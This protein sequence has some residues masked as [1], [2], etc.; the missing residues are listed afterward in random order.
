MQLPGALRA[1]RQSTRD[2]SEG[3]GNPDVP[4]TPKAPP[5]SSEQR[6][7]LELPALAG[8][9]P[10]TH[11]ADAE[12]PSQRQ[13]KLWE[14]RDRPWNQPKKPCKIAGFVEGL[15]YQSACHAAHTYISEEFT[16]PGPKALPHQSKKLAPEVHSKVV[17]PVH[18][19]AI[20]PEKIA[21]TR[22]SV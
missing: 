4:R 1:F 19:E 5:A 9:R 7:H 3:P 2:H 10:S 12:L 16:Q 15:L 13:V 14:R 8:R 17:A 6:Q 18:R 11:R 21:T 22:H 20:G